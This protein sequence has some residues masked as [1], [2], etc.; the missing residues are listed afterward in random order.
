VLLVSIEVA[1]V[2]SNK[3][4]A[5]MITKIAVVILLLSPHLQT[6]TAQRHMGY[7]IERSPGQ[8]TLWLS[9]T[10]P[11]KQQFVL[12]Y[13]KGFQLGFRSGCIT[14][15]DVNPPKA[16]SLDK[17]PLER[18]TT[19]QLSYSNGVEYYTNQITA[20]YKRYPGDGDVSLPWLLRAFSDS[21][22]K[23]LQDIDA[24]GSH[25]RGVQP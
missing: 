20:F 6:L 7:P 15:F 5:S 8:G 3:S 4:G 16:F 19:E 12:G 9:L 11:Q 21:E 13:L 1:I 23:T 24:M 18:C 25:D 22:Q 14:Y 2:I 17:S 10:E